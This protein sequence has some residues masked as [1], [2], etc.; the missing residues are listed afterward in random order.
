[1][2][3][4]EARNPERYGLLGGA[5]WRGQVYEGPQPALPFRLPGFRDRILAR[6][7]NGPLRQRTRYDDR[8][9]SILKVR[10]NRTGQG[11]RGLRWSRRS[12]RLRR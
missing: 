4:L 1:M 12:V 10:G 6:Y 8:A 5:S 11:L 7:V 2:A 3:L 9:P